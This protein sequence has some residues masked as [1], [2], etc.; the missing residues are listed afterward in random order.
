MPD[1]YKVRIIIESIAREVIFLITYEY[2]NDQMWILKCSD[3]YRLCYATVHNIYVKRGRMVFLIKILII[4]TN[5][6]VKYEY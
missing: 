1:C 4:C 6:T 3:Y 5:L 2:V